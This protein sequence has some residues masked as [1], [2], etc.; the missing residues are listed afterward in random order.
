MNLTS[1]SAKRMLGMVTE[2]FY[3]RSEI[4]KA[5]F[6]GMGH[7]FDRAESLLHMLRHAAFPHLQP[8]EVLSPQEEKF[9]H[10]ARDMWVFVYELT[11][12]EEIRQR[13]LRRGPINPAHIEHRLCSLLNDNCDGNCNDC[14]PD[15]PVSIIEFIKNHEHILKEYI[16]QVDVNESAT[17]SLDQNPQ[18]QHEHARAIAVLREI[19]PSHLSFIYHSLI[20]DYDVETTDYHAGIVEDVIYEIFDRGESVVNL[21]N[22]ARTFNGALAFNSEFPKKED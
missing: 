12:H 18:P 9:L 2:G 22:G 21:F 17:F 14:N 6:E 19:K 7:E 11:S 1:Q 16:F 10:W 8:G 4:A 20:D 13:R 3:N 15:L 5:L